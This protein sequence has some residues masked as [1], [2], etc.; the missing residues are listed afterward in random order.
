MFRWNIWISY[1][2]LNLFVPLDLNWGSTSAFQQSLRGSSGEKGFKHL[3]NSKDFHEL[4]LCYVVAV[5]VLFN[6]TCWLLLPSTDKIQVNRS[7]ISRGH[8]RVN[9]GLQAVKKEMVV[10][11]F[12]Y[13]KAAEWKRGQSTAPKWS[14]VGWL[15]LS[16]CK[17]RSPCIRLTS[18][19]QHSNWP[20]IP[21]GSW[22]L[23]LGP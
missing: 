3:T 18:P 20:S 9:N 22:A 13:V 23:S 12:D 10:V 2:Q 16:L 4:G 5:L 15:V 17:A 6:I 1:K 7:F 21:S 19:T 11:V 14:G 8:R